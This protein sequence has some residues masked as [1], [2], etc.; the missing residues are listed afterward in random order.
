MSILLIIIIRLFQTFGNYVISISIY[1]HSAH[2]K[3]VQIIYPFLAKLGSDLA[4]GS[5]GPTQFIPV[6]RI[7]DLSIVPI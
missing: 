4:S 2:R 6:R 5:D 3:M 1:M 7:S